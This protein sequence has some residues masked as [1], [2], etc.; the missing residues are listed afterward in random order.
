VPRD[1]LDDGKDV[2]TVAGD[3]QSYGALEFQEGHP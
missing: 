3:H 2:L 1:G